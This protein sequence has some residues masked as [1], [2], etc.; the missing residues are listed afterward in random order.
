TGPPPDY[1]RRQ[2]FGRI[3]AFEHDGFQL[4]EA[5]AIARYVDDEFPGPRLQP[6]D[7][8]QRARM[9]QIV[10]ILDSYGYRPML[11]DIYVERV[12]TARDARAVDE[13]RIADAV[14]KV[15]RCLAA[16]SDLQ[17]AGGFLAG[18]RLSLADLHAAP[19]LA[20]LLA[21]PEGIALMAE[22]PGL[23]RWWQAMAGRASM[24][25]TRPSPRAVA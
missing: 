18:E 8:R 21:T 6:D 4:Y 22:L 1:P 16:I 3:P 19:M 13:G 20:Y 7:A 12:E 15:R 9:T 5:C 23:T 24:A 25:K 10:S 14:P 2:P 11:W 17:G